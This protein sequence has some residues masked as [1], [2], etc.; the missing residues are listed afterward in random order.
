MQ[1]NISTA[2]STSLANENTQLL[3]VFYEKF[4]KRDPSLMDLMNDIFEFNGQEHPILRLE[5]ITH[6]KM[7][8]INWS[9]V[10]NQQFEH[11][12]IT[13]TKFE[14]EDKGIVA[15]LNITFRNKSTGVV[16]TIPTL[17]HWRFKDGKA[18]AL[19][20]TGI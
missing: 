3:V 2:T 12:D 7:D 15:T 20:V 14:A 4:Q 18:S 6:S 9:K 10:Y 16:A 17:H 1:T 19:R 13:P 11:I 8:F 5:E